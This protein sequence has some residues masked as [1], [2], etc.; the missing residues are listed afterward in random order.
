[1]QP[2]S[3]KGSLISQQ[4]QTFPWITMETSLVDVWPFIAYRGLPGTPQWWWQ[5]W[6]FAEC[7]HSTPV[8]V[9]KPTF[10]ALPPTAHWVWCHYPLCT[11]EETRAY[12]A[13]DSLTC[14]M[15]VSGYAEMRRSE[16]RFTWLSG[17]HHSLL[18]R[19]RAGRGKGQCIRDNCTTLIAIMYSL[20]ANAKHAAEHFP[21]RIFFI[22]PRNILTLVSIPT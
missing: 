6:G 17:S 14:C 1:M 19:L 9:L 16:F 13:V 12:T 3:V 22:H 10:T 2:A 18:P 11:E 4:Q 5:W 7:A 21:E 15:E 8:W 20:L